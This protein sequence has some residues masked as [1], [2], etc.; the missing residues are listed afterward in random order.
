[1]KNLMSLVSECK[2]DLDKIG[3]KYGNVVKWSV[4]TRAKSRWGLCKT[5]SKGTFEISISAMLLS[6][7]IDEQKAKNTIVH[8][9]LHTVSGCRGHKEKWKA[10]AE[11]VNARMPQ[12]TIKRVASMQ[13]NGVVPQRNEPRYKYILRCTKCGIEIKRQKQSKVITDYKHYR[14]GKCGGNL[15][16]VL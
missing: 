3:V 10:L 13:E 9:L 1:M 16:R 15:E 12:Y 11:Y 5:L 7:D 4:N 14:C 8:E 6:D 2:S